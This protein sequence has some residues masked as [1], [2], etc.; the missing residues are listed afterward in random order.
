MEGVGG[1]LRGHVG[2]S[3]MSFLKRVIGDFD[4]RTKRK[5]NGGVIL[6]L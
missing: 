2:R 6:C 3:W 4:G 1:D 5:L